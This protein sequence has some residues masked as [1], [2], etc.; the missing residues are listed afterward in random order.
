MNKITDDTDKSIAEDLSLR[1]LEKY[2]SK[3]TTTNAP[4]TSQARASS[5][6][7]GDYGGYSSYAEWAN[8]DPKGYEKANNSIGSGNIKIGYGE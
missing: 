1:K 6:K 4:S 8:K 5:G 3:V 2:V 7:V